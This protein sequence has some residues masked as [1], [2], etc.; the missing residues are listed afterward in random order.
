MDFIKKALGEIKNIRNALQLFAFVYIVFL[1]V[2]IY[3][4]TSFSINVIFIFPLI[5]V[6][7]MF[8]IGKFFE[9][10]DRRVFWAREKDYD[11]TKSPA[12]IAASDFAKR[13]GMKI[14]YKN[15]IKEIDQ[16]KNSK[17]S[18]QAIEAILRSLESQ[19]K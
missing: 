8:V 5:L 3:L 6:G 4:K 19:N 1:F 7:F 9:H 11:Q 17:K 13:E 2:I 18:K 15:S 10:L 16:N 12:Y 14:A